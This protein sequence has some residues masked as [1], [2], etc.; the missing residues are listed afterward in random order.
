MERANHLFLGSMIISVGGL[1]YDQGDHKAQALWM[2]L[3]VIVGT[4]M[5][6][7]NALASLAGE[8]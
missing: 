5:I 1:V 2:S 3:L 6:L 8:K 4:I 7:T